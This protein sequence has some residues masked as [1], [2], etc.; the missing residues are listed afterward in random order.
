MTT[1]HTT[2]DNKAVV[3]QALAA[4]LASGDVDALASVLTDDFVHH[5]PDASAGKEEWLA[6][7]RAAYGHIAGMQVDVGHMLADGDLVMLH[8]RRRLPEGGPEITVVDIW[9]FA[10]GRIA[11][12]WEIIEPTAEAAAHMAWWA[13]PA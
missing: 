10:G 9:R 7:V 2:T 4:L 5:R 3:Q 12:A 1:A 8:S 11:E 13:L 6:A